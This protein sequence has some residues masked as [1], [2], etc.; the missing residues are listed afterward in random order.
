MCLLFV[1]LFPV[2][3][4]CLQLLRFSLP[5]LSFLLA[6]EPC[7][8]DPWYQELKS[9]QGSSFAVCK[10]F[11]VNY[12]SKFMPYTASCF[13]KWWT[14]YS[15]VIKKKSFFSLFA[16][17]LTFIILNLTGG[18]FLFFICTVFNTASSICRPSDSTV[19]EDAGIEPRTIATSAL[20]VR[21]SNH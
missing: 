3:L 9:R 14:S 5:L 4:C 19:S 1:P 12:G 20:A 6:P 7:S 8:F 13:E 2:L 16:W 17:F 10:T 11:I 21:R 15:S 18:F